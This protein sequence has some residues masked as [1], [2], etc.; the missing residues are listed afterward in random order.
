MSYPDVTAAG[1]GALAR[2]RDSRPGTSEFPHTWTCARCNDTVHHTRPADGICSSC[3]VR[4]LWKD[5]AHA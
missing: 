3:R 2:P 5:T 4:S 1:L